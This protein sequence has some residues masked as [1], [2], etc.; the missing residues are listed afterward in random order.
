VTPAAAV[1]YAT[2][3][4]AVLTAAF[5]VGWL[6][7]GQP[8]APLT[9]TRY[10]Q[11]A[12]PQLLRRPDEGMAAAVADLRDEL[13]Q[14]AA[15]TAP[16]AAP[17]PRRVWLHHPPP[18]PPPD[19]AL[20]F[21]RQVAAIVNTQGQGLAVLVTADPSVEGGHSRL[22]RVGDLFDD[23]WRVASLSM[24]EVVLQDGV[25][26]KRVPLFGAAVGAGAAVQ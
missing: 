11:P 17:R 6:A 3:A 23:R 12:S 2:G 10:A 8:P 4:A 5:A 19:V 1:L 18:P 22:L 20:V 7:P 26:E 9:L 25:S 14:S 16:G 21:R 24:S 13:A 15:A